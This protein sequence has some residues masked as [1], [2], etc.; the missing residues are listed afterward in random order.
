MAWTPGNLGSGVGSVHRGVYKDGLDLYPLKLALFSV[1]LL[2]R[3]P[4]GD[5]LK[6]GEVHLLHYVWVDVVGGQGDQDEDSIPRASSVVSSLRQP[7]PV[8]VFYL[9]IF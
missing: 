7:P 8:R 4:S 3:G 6:A 2:T 9:Y 5:G 1:T